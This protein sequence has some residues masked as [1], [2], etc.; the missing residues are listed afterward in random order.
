MSYKILSLSQKKEWKRYF[1]LLPKTQQDIYFLPEY[2]ELYEKYGDGKAQCFVFEKNNEIAL[3]PF[4]INSINELGYELEK[5]YYDIQGAYG[6]NGVVT[7]SYEKDFIDAFYEEFQLFCQQNRIIAEFT[8]FHPIINNHKFS[9]NHLNTF[10]SRTTVAVNLT[11]SIEYIWQKNYTS[12][13]RNMVRKA[14][15]NGVK[16]KQKM[17]AEDYTF[18]YKMYF[19]TMS[20]LDAEKYL[21]FNEDYIKNFGKLL[22]QNHVLLFAL[23]GEKIIGCLMLVFYG[24]YAHYHLSGRDREYGKFAANNL[25]LD[26]A[27]KY[28]SENGYDIL[29]LGGGKTDSKDDSLLKFKSNFSRVNQ[30]FYIGKRIHNTAIYTQICEKWENENLSKVKKYKGFLLKYRY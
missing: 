15:K 17:L 19:K 4:L 7:S 5:D 13:N 11:Q 10:E 27:I 18:F 22:S 26:F 23:L 25:L 12:I 9:L 1:E 8:R 2:Y 20:D 6:Y 28:T 3:Y 29:H 21:F 16:I 14:T 30:K 24:N